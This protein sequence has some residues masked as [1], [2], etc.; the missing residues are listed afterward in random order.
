MMPAHE[1]SVLSKEDLASLIA[2]C[3]SMPP[4]DT[5]KEK[6]K[7]MGPIGRVL[8]VL[9]KV[10]VLPAERINH[11]STLTT[12]TPTNAVALGKY[13]AS[14]CEG[15]HRPNMK[16][17][18]ALAPG[19]PAIPDISGTGAPGNWSEAQFISTIRKGKTPEGRLLRNKF[20]PWQNMQHFSDVELQ[21]IKSYLQS[22][23]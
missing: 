10:A 19:Y 4:V 14:T 15:C 16:G 12:S 13:L 11:E 1:S 6:L 5:K 9:D 20:M 7:E 21:S 22:I 3:K 17:G 18:T 2:Y 8:I 23:K